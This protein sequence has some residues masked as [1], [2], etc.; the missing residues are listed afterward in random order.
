[1][2]SNRASRAGCPTT[3]RRNGFSSGGAPIRLDVAQPVKEDR[4][5]TINGVDYPLVWTSITNWSLTVPAPAGT[6]AWTVEARDRYGNP[7]G[8]TFVGAPEAV[9]HD[10]GTTVTGAAPGFLDR[11]GAEPARQQARRPLLSTMTACMCRVCPGKTRTRTPGTISRSPTSNSI[12]P[13]SI[14]GS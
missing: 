10:D 3:S 8:G 12:C 5:I 9:L 13:D 4:D 6:N 7:V 1:M 14:S 2:R 11:R